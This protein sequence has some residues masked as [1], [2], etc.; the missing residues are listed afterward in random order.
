MTAS[1]DAAL[2]WF[3]IF[4]RRIRF[5]NLEERRLL[6]EDLKLDDN[7]DGYVS[8]I[9]ALLVIDAINRMRSSE[10]HKFASFLVRG[11][12]ASPLR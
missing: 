5:A 9:D 8:P 10:K 6:A 2:N 4:I 12:C 11:V 1:N 7:G 3:N